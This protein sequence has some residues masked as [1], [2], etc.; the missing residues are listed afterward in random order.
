MP[1]FI[2]YDCLILIQF[3]EMVLLHILYVVMCCV[4]RTHSEAGQNT[5]QF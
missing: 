4:V 1:V 3:K 2:N 5:Q